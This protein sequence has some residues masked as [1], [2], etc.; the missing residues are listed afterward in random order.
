MIKHDT[1][2]LIELFLVHASLPKNVYLLGAGASAGI[3]P[4]MSELPRNIL[5]RID[6]IG[7]Y[8]VEQYPKTNLRNAIGISL[9]SN[10]RIAYS[11]EDLWPYLLANHVNEEAIKLLL[12][13]EF[14][15]GF[16][17][18]EEG[19]NIF[20]Y[21]FFKL[22][23]QSY[24]TIITLNND[25]LIWKY[26]GHLNIIEPHGSIIRYPNY[27]IPVNNVPVVKKLIAEWEYP[28]IEYGI[29]SPYYPNIILPGESEKSELIPEREKA[30]KSL[31]QAETVFII[32]Y[33]FPEYDRELTGKFLDTLRENPKEIFIIDYYKA[34]ELSEKIEY[35]LKRNRI[36]CCNL[37]WARL[38]MAVLLTSQKFQKFSLTSL[39]NEKKDVLRAYNN[40]YSYQR[41]IRN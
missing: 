23:P 21:D 29:R 6:A 24:A 20:Q 9:E 36:Y 34:K 41:S 7:F 26:A 18:V 17:K 3:V 12:L 1:L 38:S 31:Q 35:Y 28:V 22:I 32:G 2:K 5:K 40:P 37:D 10:D 13:K 25:A 33:S 39:I 4:I 11:Y 14:F 8:P 16:E 19:K 27:T 30:I 15:S